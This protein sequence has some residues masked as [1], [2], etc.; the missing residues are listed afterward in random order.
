MRKKEWKDELDARITKG[1]KKLES[2]ISNEVKV[3]IQNAR[4]AKYGRR[5][6]VVL[7]MVRTTTEGFERRTNLELRLLYNE[8]NITKELDSWGR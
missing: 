3:C 7:S 6:V 2:K 1:S 4:L 8:P 5:I